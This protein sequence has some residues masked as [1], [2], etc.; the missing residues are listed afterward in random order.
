MMSYTVKWTDEILPWMSLISAAFCAIFALLRFDVYMLLM[1]TSVFEGFTVGVAL[2]IGLNQINFAC[3]LKPAVKHEEFVLNIGESL[4]EL[5][6]T[7]AAS[8]VLFLIQMPL[9]YIL[10]KKV[11]KVPWTVI[12]PL[13]SIPIGWLCDAGHLAVELLTLKSKYGMLSPNLVSSLKPLGDL[14]EGSDTLSL[15]INSGSIAVVAVL[16]T[17]ISAKIAQNRIDRSFNELIELRGLTLGHVACGVTGAM[18]PTGVFVRTSLNTSLGATHRFSQIL[19]ALLVAMIAAAMM[20]IFS[21][22]PQATIA[23]LLVVSAIR[24]TPITYLKRL[25]AESRG[26][27]C[28]CLGTALVCVAEDPVIGLAVGMIIA[29]LS[30]AKHIDKA[31]G[32]DVEERQL[33]SGKKYAVSVVGSLTYLN[34][35]SFIEKVKK[36]PGALEVNLSLQSCQV[37]DHDGLTALEKVVK[38]WSKDDE[39]VPKEKVKISAPCHLLPALRKAAW[40]ISAEGEGRV[41]SEE[42][43]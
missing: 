7:K 12:M 32:V 36:L 28:L 24:M 35:E 18:A 33:A 20:P 16:E 17:L 43:V 42:M 27:F 3:G 30:R 1:P 21:F 15:I 13:I 6:N 31:P 10:M 14:V 11:P 26:S 2:I 23:A 37:M 22:L 19:N 34:S 39:G 40:F 8:L 41:L 25:W 29:L 5:G 4:A 38:T 9:L